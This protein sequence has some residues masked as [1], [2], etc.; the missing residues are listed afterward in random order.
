MTH[1]NACSFAAGMDNNPDILSQSAML[2]ASDCHHFIAAQQPEIT[3][4]ENADEFE[5]HPMD[6]HQ[7]LLNAI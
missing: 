6:E 2:H 4:L 3:G 5:Y 7:Y 1:L